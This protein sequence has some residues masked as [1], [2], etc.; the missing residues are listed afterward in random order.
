MCELFGLSARKPQLL[1]DYLKEFY[2]HSPRHPHGWGLAVLDEGTCIEKEP[3]I[4]DDSIYLKSRLECEIKA[5]YALAHIRY[6]TRGIMT[7]DNCHPFVKADCTGRR[8]TLIH[9]GTIFMDGPCDDYTGLQKGQTDSERL[10]LYLV[11]EID[12][13]TKEKN[14]RLTARERFRILD[15]AI[16]SIS[17]GNKLN[18]LMY[19]GKY[20]Y[21][22]YNMKN[23][24]YYLKKDGAIIFSTAALTEEAWEKVPFMQL[25]ACKEGEFIFQGTRHKNEYV[26]KKSIMSRVKSVMK[27]V[28]GI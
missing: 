24:L 6:A 3:V 17:K 13:A 23:R 2:S 20:M 7:Y 19:D 16:L 25:V 18:L 26:K 10:L 5:S 27:S 28:T 21:A 9:N 14:A 4:A 1:N 15:Q 11:D 8:W 22:H 12:K